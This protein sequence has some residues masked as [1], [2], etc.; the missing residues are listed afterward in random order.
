[1]FKHTT[2]EE[3][4]NDNTID[5]LENIGE[6]GPNILCQNC[7]FLAQDELSLEVHYERIHSGYYDCALCDYRAANEESLNTHLFTCETFT[8]ENCEP[9]V[10]VKTL[11]EMKAHL[12]SE[13]TEKTNI[14]HLKLD[15]TNV[16]KVTHRTV[17]S[18]VFTKN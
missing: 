3:N 13:H 16:D 8:C 10:M 7:E 4:V 9:K 6:S 15:R 11:P 18:D 1:M 2:N 5:N 17:S 12:T 14:I